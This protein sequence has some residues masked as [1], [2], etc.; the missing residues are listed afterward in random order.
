MATAWDPA[1]RASLADR[2]ARLTAEAKPAWGKLNAAGMVA[3]LNDSYRMALGDLKIA[4]RNTPFRYP[5]LQQLLVYVLPMPRNVPT[6]PEL[7]ARC[8]QA[9]LAEEQRVFHELLNRVASARPGSLVPH[10]AF[11]HLS[12]RAWGALI[13][14]HV[15]HH[16]RQ[17]SL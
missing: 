3:H 4:P 5:P 7:I 8:G 13:A 1:F 6:A 15:D 17:F 11:G 14:K 9:E 16:F 12:H 10:P 2:I